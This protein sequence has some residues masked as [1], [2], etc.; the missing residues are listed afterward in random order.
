M[1]TNKLEAK[2][3]F[4]GH[5]LPDVQMKSGVS[6]KNLLQFGPVIFTM[7]ALSLV[8]LV[9]LGHMAVEQQRLLDVVMRERLQFMMRDLQQPVE[10]VQG[11]LVTLAGQPGVFA[12]PTNNIRELIASVL[13][14]EDFYEGLAVLDENGRVLT[15]YAE[16]NHSLTLEPGL[17]PDFRPVSAFSWRLLV[18]E[19]GREPRLAAQVPVLAEG[20]RLVGYLFAWGNLSFVRQGLTATAVGETGYG[21]LLDRDT[22]TLLTVQDD[23]LH[24]VRDLTPFPQAQALLRGEAEQAGGLYRIFNRLLFR[25]L[26]DDAVLRQETAVAPLPWQLIIEMPAAEAFAFFQQI[27][28]LTLLLFLSEVLIAVGIS[29]FYTRRILGPLRQLL[30]AATAVSS[31]NLDAQVTIK[32]PQ[33]LS[34]LGSAFNQMTVQIRELVNELE[35][36]VADRTRI[37]DRRSLQIQAAAQTARDATAAFELDELFNRAVNLVPS[38]FGYYHAGIFLVDETGKFAVLRAAT[39]SVGE[40]LLAQHHKLRIG[41]EG[42]V[43][44][45]TRTG[46][47][48]V[49]A[50]TSQ[51]TVYWPNPLLP[52]TRSEMAL[53]LL[54]DDRIIGVMNVQSKVPGA[55]DAEDITILQILTDQLAV[56]I[57]KTRLFAQNQAQLEERL[58]TIISNLPVVLFSFDH[59]GVITLAEGQGLAILRATDQKFVGRKI[60]DIFRTSAHILADIQ[61]ALQGTAVNSVVMLRGATWDV[62]YLP[63]LTDAGEVTGVIGVA[64]D[65]SERIQAVASLQEKEAQLRQIIDTVPQMIFAKDRHG[66]FLLANRA[67]ANAYQTTVDALI[68]TPQALWHTQPDELAQFLQD[69]QEVLRTGRPKVI[70][71]IPFTDAAG[72]VRTLQVTKIPFSW[73][74]KDETAALGVAIDITERKQADAA[75]RQAQKLESLGVLAGG[76]AHD[77]NNLL[78]AV[79]GQTS[80][81]LARLPQES[82]AYKAI[83][84]AVRAAER[85]AD[86][87]RQLLAYSGRGHFQVRR[88]NLNDLIRENLHL[89]EVAVPKHVQLRS[90]LYPD[91]P[92]IEADEGQMQQVIMNLILNGAEALADKAGSVTVTTGIQLLRDTANPFWQIT[93]EELPPGTYLVLT[94]QDN[95]QGMDSETVQRIFDPFFTTKHTGR[96]LGLAA[97]L[98]I[99]R[100]HRGGIRVYSEVGKGTL[101]KVLLPVAEGEHVAEEETAVAATLPLTAHILVIDDEQPVRDTIA[102]MLASAGFSATLAA[103]GQEGVDL[104][105]EKAGNIDLIIL[106]LSMP[107]MSGEETFRVLR[108]ID[109][110]VPILLSSGYNQT[111]ATQQFVGRDLAGFLQKPYTTEALLAKVRELIGNKEAD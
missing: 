108:Q 58:R 95:G 53:P 100:G 26:Y 70:P 89:F 54:V 98:G 102:D 69:D 105:A 85:A 67:T 78:V 83:G 76:V 50:D 14:Y 13:F 7:V 61:Q 65:I 22:G 31:G 94:V 49:T 20:E 57:E 91:L 46:Q 41:A 42:I 36:R 63:M 24:T 107:G 104:F 43:G 34:F 15:V 6:L 87:T 81:A 59:E 80:L 103:D 77:F 40:Q 28:N 8:I 23:V 72:Q 56:A 25:G 32:E 47:P 84:K 37:L 66:R 11:Q 17:L 109:T 68:G 71:E 96:G 97:V 48:Y 110:T 27:A 90:D 55:F 19:D 44:Y 21:Y 73:M 79:L 29:L 16:D 9:M 75:L 106:D 92:L 99:V 88:L 64:N 1:T 60:T 33:E 74:G 10:H 3:D 12:E 30:A 35:Q 39:G 4:Q 101:F 2:T 111:E 62:R 52:E 5:R 18:E 38:R 51:D 86:L 45:V 82:P 93:G